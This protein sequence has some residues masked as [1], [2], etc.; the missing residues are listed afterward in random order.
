MSAHTA[1]MPFIHFVAANVLS[2]SAS[3]RPFQS[4]RHSS[5]NPRWLSSPRLQRSSIESTALETS[6]PRWRDSSRHAEP[7]KRV[8]SM[9][10]MCNLLIDYSEAGRSELTTDA[11]ERALIGSPELCDQIGV[12]PF[13][14]LPLAPLDQLGEVPFFEEFAVAEDGY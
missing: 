12:V 11:G 9:S 13:R 7:F 5:Q 3:S 14:V 4:G 2:I 1:S 10:K 8:P 6:S